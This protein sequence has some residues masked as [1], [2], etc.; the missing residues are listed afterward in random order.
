MKPFELLLDRI[1][2]FEENEGYLPKVRISRAFWNEYAHEIADLAK[3]DI[4]INVVDSIRGPHSFLLEK[5]SEKSLEIDTLFDLKQMVDKWVGQGKGHWPVRCM[6]MDD[7]IYIPIQL[8]AIV[9]GEAPLDGLELFTEFWGAPS[10]EH[11]LV[12]TAD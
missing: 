1:N 8:Y 6:S 9:P 12:I 11:I 10:A 5:A 2:Q 7:D 4:S 3:D